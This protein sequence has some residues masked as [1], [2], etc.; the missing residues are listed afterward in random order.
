MSGERRIFDKGPHIA[1]RLHKRGRDLLDYGIDLRRF[2]REGETVTAATA[3]LGPVTTPVMS[4]NRLEFGPSAVMVWL[5][6]GKDGQSYQVS[7]LIQTS[8]DR[9][10]LFRFFVT[11]RGDAPT[12]NLDGEG[13]P[14]G[15]FAGMHP[16]LVLAPTHVTFPDTLVGV[17]SAPIAVTV[18]NIGA[19][20]ATINAID[21]SDDFVTTSNTVGTLEQDEFFTLWVTVT[22]SEAGLIGGYVAIDG[23]APAQ[24]ILLAQ[25]I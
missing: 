20:R 3:W 19:L 5:D 22:P 18:T 21:V 13:Q 4:I 12:H 24:L 9:E 1:A 11:V 8:E 23:N 14:I 25:G 15:I 2:L 7:T 17:A 10:K 16:E 6:G